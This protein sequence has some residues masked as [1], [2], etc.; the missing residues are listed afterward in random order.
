VPT[1]PLDA[2]L[3]WIVTERE[4][5]RCAPHDLRGRTGA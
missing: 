5:I 1:G 4:A 2:P 3:D